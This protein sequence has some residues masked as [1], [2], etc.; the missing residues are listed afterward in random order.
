M[1]S[2]QTFSQHDYDSD[3]AWGKSIVARHIKALG[4]EVITPKDKYAIDMAARKRETNKIVRYEVEVKHGYPW[5]NRGDFPFPTVSF[6]ARKAKYS[7]TEFWYC[8]V[9]KE[10]Q[11]LIVAHSSVIFKPEHKVVKNVNKR[12]RQGTDTFY[13]VSVD[14]CLF[15]GAL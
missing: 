5:T 6:L 8:I 11:A 12:T 9:C 15:V 2:A 10:T 7:T 3:D 13:E 14:Q 1:S 4:L